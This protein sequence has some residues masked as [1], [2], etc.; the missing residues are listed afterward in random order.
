M[1]SFAQEKPED[2]DTTTTVP[3]SLIFWKKGAKLNL[4]V[5]QVGL[6]N[7]AAGGE[8]SV[9]IGGG[10]DGFIN[11]EKD[12]ILWENAAQIGYGVIRNGGGGNRF[13]KTDDQVLLSSKYSQKFS[14]KVLMTSAIN[15]RTQMDRGYKI[16]NIPNS[17]ETRRTLISNFMAPGYLQASLGLTFRDSKKGYTATLAPFTGRF[18]FVL[19]DS[20]SKAGAF[21][22]TPNDKVRSEAGISLRGGYQKDIMENVK[23]QT[24]FNLF[25]NYEKFPNTVVNVEAVLNLKVN[26]FIQSNISTQLIYDD[27]VIVTRSDGSQGRDLQIK[28]VINVGFVLGF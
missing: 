10:I 4:T 16:E 5:Q 7:W 6:T 21:G 26:D 9:A 11:Y 20:L 13:E 18:T 23:F 12:E 3:D 8:S 2:K 22:I 25:S 24:N 15:F 27:D 28:N 1:N 17:S 19:N 14:E